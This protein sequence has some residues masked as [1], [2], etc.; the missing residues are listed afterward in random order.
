MPDVNAGAGGAGG[1][2]VYVDIT[3]GETRRVP[4]DIDRCRVW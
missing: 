4:G 1:I 3:C 2:E